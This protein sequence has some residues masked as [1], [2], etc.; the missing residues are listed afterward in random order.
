MGEPRHREAEG[1]TPGHRASSG[2]AVTC[3]QAAWVAA[4]CNSHP[5]LCVKELLNLLP[6]QR[7]TYARSQPQPLPNRPLGW[8]LSSDQSFAWGVGNRVEP[9]CPRPPVGSWQSNETRP[10][11][12]APWG[13]RMKSPPSQ[14]PGLPGCGPQ[15][16]PPHPGLLSVGAPRSPRCP[17][18]TVPTDPPQA[19]TQVLTPGV[20]KR[21]GAVPGT[22]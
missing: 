14:A 11:Q 2:R 17:I 20:S 13:H 22:Q 19:H 5:L 9:T 8:E 18:P 1:L 7:V 21:S 4:V 10:L 6:W 16:I 12:K 3:T 15:S